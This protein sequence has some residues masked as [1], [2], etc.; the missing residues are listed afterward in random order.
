MIE[1]YCVV[2]S[3]KATRLHLN[4]YYFHAQNKIRFR[5]YDY[6]YNFVSFTFILMMGT[7]H[8]GWKDFKSVEDSTNLPPI[9][10]QTTQDFALNEKC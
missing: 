10:S 1:G 5:D 4:A 8:G 9:P 3:S 6:F 7:K 2:S